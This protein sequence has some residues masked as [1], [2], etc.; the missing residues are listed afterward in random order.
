MLAVA[1]AGFAGLFYGASDFSGAAAS[2][3]NHPTVVTLGVQLVSAVAL[4][5]ALFL[6]PGTLQA[7]DVI[8]GAAG[9]L[10]LAAG[11]ALF[12]EALSTGPIATAAALTALVSSSLP[13]ITGLLLGDELKPLTLVGVGLAVPAAVLVSAGEVGI[14]HNRTN[15]TPRERVV[16]RRRLA[17]TRMLS[18]G[19]G[20][21]FAGF[22]VAL[23]QVSED[24]GLFPLIG[25]RAA[26]IGLLVILITAQGVWSPISRRSTPMVLG[27]GLFDCS[28][29]GF[30]VTA[31]AIGDLTWVSAISSLAPVSTVLL[32]RIFFKE[33]LTIPQ[34]AGLAISVAALTLVAVGRTL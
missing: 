18:V 25:T 9:G 10:S 20:T 32:A 16:G 21:L 14:H 4:A 6:V 24:A 31:F 33:R 12:Y 30:L 5:G 23:G 17:R 19:A 26:A 13:I 15:T 3:G 27:A 1:L 34:I 22:L 11:L 8:W 28:A 2:R 7:S 29:D